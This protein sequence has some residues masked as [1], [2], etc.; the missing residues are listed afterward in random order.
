MA[1]LEKG[2]QTA[3][4]PLIIKTPSSL[5]HVIDQYLAVIVTTMSQH[6]HI[7]LFKQRTYK[8]FTISIILLLLI[9]F[10]F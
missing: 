10:R 4:V 2:T 7:L 6:D 1:V 5:H 8:I 3:N 9:D